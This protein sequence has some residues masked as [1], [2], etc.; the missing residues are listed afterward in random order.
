MGMVGLGAVMFVIGTTAIVALAI[1]PL[2]AAVVLTLTGLSWIVIGAWG[3][4]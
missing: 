2:T 3:S 1:T 4:Q